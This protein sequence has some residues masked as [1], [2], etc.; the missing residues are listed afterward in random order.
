MEAKSKFEQLQ[1]LVDDSVR[2][3]W[4]TEQNALKMKLIEADLFDWILDLEDSSKTTLKQ[5]DL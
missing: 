5:V 1:T 4:E 3:A 2:Q